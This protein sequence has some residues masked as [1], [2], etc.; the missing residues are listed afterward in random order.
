MALNDNPDVY[1]LIVNELYP[2]LAGVPSHIE[3]SRQVSI[4]KTSAICADQTSEFLSVL[5]PTP[6]FERLIQPLFAE[7]ARA[8]RA[9]ALLGAP[10]AYACAQLCD[11]PSVDLGALHTRAAYESIQSAQTRSRAV[12]LSEKLAVEG[13]GAVAFKGLATALSV[14]PY[15][16]YRTLPDVDLLFRETDLPQLAER[17][18]AWGYVTGVDHKTLRAWG[19]L[20]EASFAPIFQTD[21]TFFLDVHRTFNE[22]PAS[23]GLHTELIFADANKVETRWG[24]CL[25][26]SYEHSFVIAALNL[27]RDFYRPEALKGIFDA[28]LILTRFGS[29]LDWAE[30]EQIARRGS[31]VTRLVFFRDLLETLGAGRA[32]LFEEK[33]L[34]DWLRPSLAYVAENF[35]T[36]DRLALSDCRKMI[37]EVGLQDSALVILRSHW[38]RLRGIVAPPSHYLPGLPIATSATAPL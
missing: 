38:Q 8:D 16:A 11:N 19:P 27:Y 34:A 18:A 36:L 24:P 23:L 37:L 32:P 9:T 6:F 31:F 13:I 30:I 17:L 5:F 33:R 12:A 10:L 35:R 15:A 14:Y 22:R 20:T 7:S 21:R 3:Q 28:C 25:V 29:A 1:L 4:L 26:P 2:L